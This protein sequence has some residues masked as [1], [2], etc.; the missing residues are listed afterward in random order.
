MRRQIKQYGHGWLLPKN[1]SAELIARVICKLTNAKI[2]FARA[3]TSDFMAN[4]HWGFY[5][6]RL[7]R[8][9]GQIENSSLTK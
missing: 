9:Y 3:R 7:L 8:L 4:N 5:E 1:P 6:E 2:N